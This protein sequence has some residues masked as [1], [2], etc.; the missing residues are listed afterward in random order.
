MGACRLATPST[1]QTIDTLFSSSARLHRAAL[2][3]AL[4]RWALGG[5]SGPPA[6]LC[7][8]LFALAV[9]PGCWL[10]AAGCGCCWLAAV[11]NAGNQP[12]RCRCSASIASPRR[13][14]AYTRVLIGNRNRAAL[15][16]VG[17]ALIL[18]ACWLPAGAQAAGRRH[19]RRAA[20]VQ[21]DCR[22]KSG[23]PWPGRPGCP[24]GP[25]ACPV[26]SRRRRAVAA[27]SVRMYAAA[28]RARHRYGSIGP[29][30]LTR[31]QTRPAGRERCQRG[32]GGPGRGLAV[33]L[34]PLSRR[35]QRSGDSNT[36]IRCSSSLRI[37]APGAG[38]AAR[39]S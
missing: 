4:A 39:S 13:A 3:W 25:E 10:L 18:A 35:A 34:S 17:T 28:V 22:R 38:R 33:P 24:D 1:G 14:Y 32:C 37:P 5:E 26:D 9:G 11:L 30:R 16:I 8:L 7:S 15:L 21:A 29:A 27:R 2:P 20:K 36:A 6:A 31:N 12:A 19:A 23:Q